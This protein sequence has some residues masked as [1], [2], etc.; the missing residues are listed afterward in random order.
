MRWRR[1]ST[2]SSSAASWGETRISSRSRSAIRWCCRSSRSL[3]VRSFF[4]W[5]LTLCNIRSPH[6]VHA[7]GGEPRPDQAALLGDPVLRADPDV[8]AELVLPP[9]LVGVLDVG[10]S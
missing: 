8:V 7:S 10:E 2:R 1:A 5:L 3:I 6:H 4:T 9:G